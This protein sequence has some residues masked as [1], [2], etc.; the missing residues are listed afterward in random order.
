[1]NNI[2][3]YGKYIKLFVFTMAFTQPGR[4]GL[5]HEARDFHTYDE[6]WT[7][8]IVR[9]TRVDNAGGEVFDAACIRKDDNTETE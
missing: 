4:D 5:Q 7:Y 9:Q 2:A 6:C 1:M 8:A 3:L